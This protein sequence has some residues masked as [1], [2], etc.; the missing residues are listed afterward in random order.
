ME[1]KFQ[2]KV[3]ARVGLTTLTDDE[4]KVYFSSDW[5]IAQVKARREKLLR[6]DLLT[7]AFHLADAFGTFTNG[8][9]V[10]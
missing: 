9:R 6:Q 4:A 3:P 1:E 5:Y 8:K 2:V 10:R 7:P